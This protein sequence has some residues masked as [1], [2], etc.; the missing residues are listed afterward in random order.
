MHVK[1]S[2]CRNLPLFSKSN[3]FAPSPLPQIDLYSQNLP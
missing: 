3:S 1:F 2:N